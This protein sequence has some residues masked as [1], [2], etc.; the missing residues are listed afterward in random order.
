[1]MVMVL[2]MVMVMVLVL[3]MV[4]VIVMVMVM[5]MVVVIMVVMVM[6]LFTACA[7]VFAGGVPFEDRRPR[8]QF[9]EFKEL[10]LLGTWLGY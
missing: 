2:V 6:V 9:G 3:V 1:M 5:V 10:F 8:A 7:E 4:M